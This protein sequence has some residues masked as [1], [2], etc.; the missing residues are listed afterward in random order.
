MTRSFEQEPGLDLVLPDLAGSGFAGFSW[1]RLKP[2]PDPVSKPDLYP[3][4]EPD[5]LNSANRIQL[6]G[7]GSGSRSGPVQ[8]LPETLQQADAAP[9]EAGCILLGRPAVGV[10][11]SSW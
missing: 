8:A 1:I 10:R 4:I 2:G 3:D 11:G 5:P 6:Y 9:G 7:S